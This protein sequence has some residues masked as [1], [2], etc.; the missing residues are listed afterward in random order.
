MIYYRCKCGKNEYFGSGM[1]P[2]D[3][4]GCDECGTTLSTH[5]EG[6]KP[7]APHEWET[8]YDENTGKPYRR[9]KKCLEKEG[10]VED[11]MS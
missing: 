2:H 1:V 6:H 7:R 9:C 3:C 10:H 4:E 11:D 8:K 5:P